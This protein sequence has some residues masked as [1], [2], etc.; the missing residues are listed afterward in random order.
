MVFRVSKQ[1]M[2]V[3]VGYTGGAPSECADWHENRF[4]SFLFGEKQRKQ[5]VQNDNNV[6]R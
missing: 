2:N 1:C 3:C 5:C 4:S 6:D